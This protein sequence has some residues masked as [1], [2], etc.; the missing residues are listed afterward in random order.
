[1]NFDH[2]Q[3]SATP[4]ESDPIDKLLNQLHM[5]SVF[6]THSQ[7]AE[8]W[9]L[10]MPP[11]ANCMMF[12]LITEG[13]CQFEI[14][15]STLTLNAGD[16][17][18][19]PK[20]E[21]HQL[22]DGNCLTVTPLSELPIKALTARYETLVFGGQGIPTKL[23]C[24]ALIFNHPIALKLLG[25]LPSFIVIRQSQPETSTIVHSI[26]TLI[27]SESQQLEMGA[28]ALLSRLADI[29]VITAIR[30]HLKELNGDQTNWL[31]AL[32][33]D[34][35][36]KALL[37]I[38]NQPEKHWSLEELAIE[39]GMSRTGFAQQ[40]KQLIGNTP[41][42]YLTEWRMSLAFSKLQ[43]SQDTLLSIALDIGYQSEAAFSRAFKKIIG[44]SPGEVRKASLV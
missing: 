7:L 42:E 8:P 6:Y 12:H 41:I 36:S 5:E 17:I 34:K 22:S 15:N 20:G 27:K 32:H 40:F 9:A 19:F 25:V 13:R 43:S 44:K 26:S 29:L 23:I 3:R 24:G 39:V 4:I 11:M 31:N 2:Q 37:L 30:Q 18:L 21:G 38:H 10:G 14:N 1:M 16:F 33:N 28:E 35:I